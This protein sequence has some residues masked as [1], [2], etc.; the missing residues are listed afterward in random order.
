[1]NKFAKILRENKFRIILYFTAGQIVAFPISFLL[2]IQKVK[3]ILEIEPVGPILPLIAILVI[4][5][6]LTYKPASNFWR[7][8]KNNYKLKNPPFTCADNIA[9][10]L[11]SCVLFS[12]IFRERLWSDIFLSSACLRILTISGVFGIVWVICTYKGLFVPEEKEDEKGKLKTEE[13]TVI[14]SDEAITHENEDI[15]ERK[16]FVRDLYKQIVDFPFSDSFVIGLYGGWGEGKTSVLNLL[17]NKLLKNEK[18]ILV[19]F[20]PWYFRDEEALLKN[21]YQSIENA[22]NRVYFFPDFNKVLRKY[23]NILN[24]GLKRFGLDLHGFMDDEELEWIKKRI[25]FYIQRIERKLII[26]I[27]NIDRLPSDEVLSVFKLVKLSAKF[28]NTIFV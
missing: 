28:K 12:L 17:R 10:L 6:L 20:D 18:V 7:R 21:F 4:F 24:I 8:Y 3:K 9:V 14:L 1:V 2:S 27:D 22:I 25:D 23:Q 16:S 5:F 13:S 19:E 26:F 15:L 11:F